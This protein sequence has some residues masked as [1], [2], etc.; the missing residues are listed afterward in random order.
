[1]GIVTGAD[2]KIWFT[3]VL[4]FRIGA[5]RLSTAAP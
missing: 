4:D 3:E 2:Q 5:L 1:L